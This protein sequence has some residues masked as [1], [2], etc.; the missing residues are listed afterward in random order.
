MARAPVSRSF[1]Q[2]TIL[3]ST[4]RINEMAAHHLKERLLVVDDA[5]DT[6]EVVQRN[7]A[8]HGYEVFTAGNVAEAK[9]FL[10]TTRIDM[11]ITDLKMPGAPGLDLVH[12]VHQNLP[13]TAV[14]MITGYPFIAEA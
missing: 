13:D 5:P 2:P 10:E 6:R 7:L 9:T 1:F 8:A 12:H 3:R 14:M 4:R 11:V